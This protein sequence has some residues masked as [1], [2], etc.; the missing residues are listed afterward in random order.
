MAKRSREQTGLYIE[1][2]NFGDRLP[3]SGQLWSVS[4]AK[5]F[6]IAW[7]N[8]VRFPIKQETFT[9]FAVNNDGINQAFKHAAIV[10]APRKWKFR[11]KQ[12]LIT[13]KKTSDGHVAEQILASS[14]PVFYHGF[15]V[16]RSR[17]FFFEQLLCGIDSTFPIQTLKE[18]VPPAPVKNRQSIEPRTCSYVCRNF[19]IERAWCDFLHEFR[20]AFRS[21]LEF[22]GR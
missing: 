6:D 12:R 22:A 8:I 16:G 9:S 2:G 14:L 15:R 10:P 4:F 1:A 7:G 13:R 5:D 17:H 20:S 18:F 3:I 19:R 11:V 21:A